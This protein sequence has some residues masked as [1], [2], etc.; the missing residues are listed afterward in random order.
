[1][2]V[3]TRS[4]AL[5]A[6]IL[7]TPAAAQ[8]A[9]LPQMPRSRI[10]D[11][12]NVDLVTGAYISPA[13]EVSIGTDQSG[14]V[15]T[16]KLASGQW[17][18]S[19]YHILLETTATTAT[20][21]FGTESKKFNGSGSTFTPADADGSTLTFNSG[22]Q[23]YTFTSRDGTIITIP[24]ASRRAST[25]KYPSGALF[26]LYY[27]QNTASGTNYYRLRSIGTSN[28]HQVRLTYSLPSMS[29]NPNN[30]RAWAAPSTVRIVNNISENCQAS[31]AS[32][33][34]TGTWPMLIFSGPLG[35][36][37]TEPSGDTRY[38]SAQY[39]NGFYRVTGIKRPSSVTADNTAISYDAN[40][41]VAQVVT[42]G[43]TWTY[44]YSLAGS[45]MTT[46]V[47][48]PGETNPRVI[49]SDVNLGVPLSQQD[50]LGRT[51]SYQYDPAGN[52]R[53]TRI[54]HPEGN[55]VEYAYDARGN[56][57]QSK[58]VSKTPGTPVDIV[59]SATFPS[60]CT[61]PLTCNK[62][63]S[64]TDARGN[65]TD[66]TYN[67]I[68]GGL[69]TLT[70]PAPTVGA[71]RPQT[72]FDYAS[73]QAYFRNSSGSIVASGVP[74][75][76]M[77]LT[78]ECQ[79]LASCA[80]GADEVKTTI[81]YGPQVAGTANNLWPISVS[82]GS[83]NGSLTATTT[84]IYSSQ[85][86]VNSVDGPLAG[87][88]DRTRFYYDDSRRAWGTIE[89]DPDGA[90]PL[91]NRARRITFA[92]DN[93]IKTEYG[94]TAGQGPFAWDTFD[95]LQETETWYD[96]SGRKI[97]D[98][99][100]SGGDAFAV[101]H[102][103]YDAK[104][105][106]ECV[107]QR[108]NP[109]AFEPSPASACAPGTLGPQGPDRITKSVYNSADEVTQTQTAV[110]TSDAETE[111]TMTYTGNGKLQ[112][113]KDAEDNLTTYE[114]DGHDRLSKT[115]MPSTAKGSGT[116]ST[117]DYEQLTYDAASNITQRRL[118]DAQMISLT[119]DTLNRVI[120]K[121]LPGSTEWDET[122]SYDNLGRRTGAVKGPITH[123]FAYDALSR[124]I[125][126]G[127]IYGSVSRQFDL[128]DR[129]TRTSWWDGFYVDYD[130]LVTGELS[131]VRENGATSG[132]GLLAQ[133]TYDSL[134][135]R[136]VLAR[137][138]GALTY[139]SY[140]PVSR[141]T[142]VT[143]DFA[144]NAFDVGIGGPMTYNPAGQIV[145]QL[146]SN[147]DYAFT[148]H[149]SGST[150]SAADGLNR[151]VTFGGVGVSGDARG[152]MTSDPTT[153]RSFVY[154]PQNELRTSG[155]F[156]LGYDALLRPI[157]TATSGTVT[158]R[159]TYD[160]K[161]IVAATDSAI[162]DRY[163]WGDGPDEL[164]VDYVGSGTAN[165]RW[166][167]QDERG[168]VIA[169]SDAAGN[170]VAM[171]K[172]DEF[173]KPQS[174]NA[175]RFQ[176]TG[177]MWLPEISLYHYKARVYSPT[178]GG[179][180]LQTD[181]VGYQDSPNLYVYARNDPTN[182]IDPTGA[183][184]Y[185]GAHR[186]IAWWSPYLH[187]KIY[188]IP[189]NQSAYRGQFGFTTNAQG[190]VFTTIGA[191][192]AGGLLVGELGRELDITQ[193]SWVLLE[194]NPGSGY[195]EDQIISILLSTQASYCNCLTYSP[196]PEFFGG[197]NSNSYIAGILQAAGLSPSLFY[198][199]GAFYPLIDWGA[200]IPGI[201]TPIPLEEEEEE[202]NDDEGD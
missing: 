201:F 41:R 100:A 200:I 71:I 156:A 93:V 109:A 92:A 120:A 143:H 26:S 132:P 8:L 163:V 115:R 2:P 70:L 125:S 15:F 191:E 119:Y 88:V 20:M 58:L 49:V 87:N 60:T 91:G 35:L 90:G 117:T 68:H 164:L 202:E 197:Y 152:N 107:A 12:N 173:G 44:G 82:K 55:S 199:L 103:G 18:I 38:T 40:G 167:H 95:V 131:K 56:A 179:R 33:T 111:R 176:Y 50:A 165:R 128:A 159:F 118:R 16:Q 31:A 195:T 46:A 51:T 193:P 139:Y 121:D 108:M 186:A 198:A 94:T 11:V 196:F 47:T 7:A 5:L 142:G 57:T 188:I 77:T 175:G 13:A 140:D 48:D 22:T 14:I 45:Q 182:W 183:E 65:V 81:G 79:T 1:M 151:L 185:L 127:Q 27:D 72:R 144:N 161:Q 135:R 158:K 24:N 80:G 74:T 153:G 178:F 52:G 69:L 170:V 146:R 166:A 102:Y 62:P 105:R 169:L 4:A 113:L 43:R 184:I 99:L 78:S 21:T 123:S 157:D 54:T 61:N 89:P 30:F 110:G 147:D 136:T 150:A 84:Y 190:T 149:G 6:G 112:T 66:Y 67:G 106:L 174:G 3:T 124:Q 96:V 171:N 10:L 177:Q 180:F 154:G 122:Y 138:N 187:L 32:C 59:T 25:I 133:F 101:T 42:D 28:G 39:S 130:R 126:E 37:V 64:A 155:T 75:W 189:N 29:N 145:S 73:L 134:R 104:G 192:P 98:V 53:L 168:S 23:N 137:G 129:M 97:R 148:G 17:W 36:T 34:F 160:G 181:P 114:Y 141:L 162:A 63:T 85:G 116:S 76:Q 194:L 86:D 83:G 172:Y 19:N 9:S